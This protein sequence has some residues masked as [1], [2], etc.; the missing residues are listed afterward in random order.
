[1]DLKLES[2]DGFLLATVVGQVS[3][4]EA[5]KVCKKSCDA[6]VRR[7]FGKILFD[8]LGLTGEISELER[9]ELGKQAAEYCRNLSPTLKTA[10]IGKPPTVDGFVARV[11]SNRGI[12]VETFSERQAALDWLNRF[13]SKA[14]GS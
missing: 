14:A 13:G 2:R 7:G 3:L 1:M 8:F 9:Y 4:A 6:A 12:V 11:A 10:V 5:I